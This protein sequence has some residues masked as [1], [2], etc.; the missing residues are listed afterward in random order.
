MLE[1]KVKPVRELQRIIALLRKRK[2]KVVF[3]NGCFDLLHYG[4]VRYLEEARKKGDLLVVGLNSDRSVQRLKGDKRPVVGQKYRA[5][6]LA[7]LAS[8]DY[9]AIFEQDTPL[10]IIKRLKP[11][12]LVKGSDWRAEDIVGSD[13]VKSY[14]GKVARVRF[15]KGFSTT[16]ILKNIVQAS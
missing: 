8:V 1:K 4:H 16:N 10:K 13:F 12:V 3:T 7:A 5:R 15:L 6:V 11:D 2:K 9:V 14:G